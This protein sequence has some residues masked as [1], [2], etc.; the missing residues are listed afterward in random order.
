VLEF[1]AFLTKNAS[2]RQIAALIFHQME[3]GEV[4]DINADLSGDCMG[5]G[6]L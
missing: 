1:T 4:A 5:M 2:G 3:I 6:T